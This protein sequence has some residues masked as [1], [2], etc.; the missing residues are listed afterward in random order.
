MKL[1]MYF[2][3]QIMIKIYWKFRIFLMAVRWIFQVNLDDQV[4]YN[5]RC[6]V[7]CNGVRKNSWQLNGLD[8]GDDG[9]VL[10]SECFAVAFGM[11]YGGGSGEERVAEIDDE[12]DRGEERD[13]RNK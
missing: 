10:R 2:M 5:N 11:A 7:V 1:V 4:F 13:K 12:E 9:W 8:N 6:Y 3:R